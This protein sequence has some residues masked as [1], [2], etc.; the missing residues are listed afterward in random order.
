[1]G[2]GSIETGGG[3]DLS[4]FTQYIGYG[5]YGLLGVFTFT[6]V[7]GMIFGMAR[8]WKRTLKR[9]LV[10]LPCFIIAL[11]LAPVITNLLVGSPL[12]T[13][14]EDEL[15]RLAGTDAMMAS[16]FEALNVGAPF[17]LTF[18]ISIPLILVNI[19]IYYVLVLFFRYVFT[20]IFSVIALRKIAPKRDKEG[21]KI[22][23]SK[24]AGMGMGLLFGLIIFAFMW[25]PVTGMMSSLNEINKYNPGLE[26]RPHFDMMSTG[27]SEI[28]SVNKTISDVN[29][30]V[31]GGISG[32]IVGNPVNQMI[33]RFGLGRLAT[34]SAGSVTANMQREAEVYFE[35]YRDAVVIIDLAT[36]MDDTDALV[37]VFSK[38]NDVAYFRSIINKVF[39]LGTVRIVLETDFEKFLRN[40]DISDMMPGE[41]ESEGETK[42]VLEAVD[43]SFLFGDD[44]EMADDFRDAIYKALGNINTNFIK[45]DILKMLEVARL[46]FAQHQFADNPTDKR[47]LWTTAL[48]TFDAFAGDD[49]NVVDTTTGLLDVL[50]LRGPNQTLFG[51]L[52]LTEQIWATIAG[53]N[54]FE[55]FLFDS[56]NEDLYKLPIKGALENYDIISFVVG[57]DPALQKRFED[58]LYP[59]IWDIGS[60]FF[61]DD[62]ASLIDVARLVFEEHPVGYTGTTTLWGV[63]AD[64]WNAVSGGGL[65]IDVIK[66]ISEDLSY[67]LG[68]KNTEWAERNL[69]QQIFHTL[70]S[71]NTLDNFLL[72]AKNSDLYTLPAAMFLNELIPTKPEDIEINFNLVMNG[73][74]NIITRVVDPEV[75]TVIF[76]I[77]EAGLSDIP[78]L[79][80]IIAGSDAIVKIGEILEILTNDK[81]WPVGAEQTPTMGI[82]K[83]IRHFLTG[84]LDG[85]RGDA[86]AEEAGIGIMAASDEGGPDMMGAI[87]DSLLDKLAGGNIAWADELQTI[88][89]IAEA[90]NKLKLLS[91][92]FDPN[93]IINAL[94]DPDSDFDLLDLIAG[95]PLLAGLVVDVLDN[96][97]NGL[98][99]DLDVGVQF[100]FDGTKED[101]GKVIEAV[102]ALVTAVGEN[103]MD[104]LTDGFGEDGD[105]DF[106][107]IDSIINDLFTGDDNVLDLLADSGLKINVTNDELADSINS[108][109]DDMLKDEH[110]EELT[111]QALEDLMNSPKWKFLSI[112][113]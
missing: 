110:G 97:I 101:P 88:V 9:M 43:F 94:L 112:F 51:G 100:N 105:V 20:P 19:F 28:D 73:M 48:D 62:L 78:A 13:M 103:I 31:N 81:D 65:D 96:V 87:I 32:M 26:A 76:E 61:R 72:D 67:I 23:H 86:V 29:K 50:T 46:T 77:Y 70:G 54:I 18:I 42:G 66:N 71:L 33:G 89:D 80:D 113:G 2:G 22:R 34:V 25:I 3:F 57:D 17:A 1:M 79:V 60:S 83:V 59:A 108:L 21:N 74:A 40:L 98:L 92:N 37:D 106:E 107:D 84:F 111:G 6:V 85:M 45:N 4:G 90:L 93:D 10:L 91:G 5:M 38:T 44:E 24:L 16:I 53:M 75:A 99:D 69:V 104:W 58:A 39:G 109:K 35:L 63:G 11:L 64:A 49:G 27:I 47:S 52:T 95:S 55:N 102:G 30:E 68:V 7:I 82:N 41:T 12:G 14:L 8:G 56:T 36:D 15:S